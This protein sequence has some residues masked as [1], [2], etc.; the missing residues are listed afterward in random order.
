[1]SPRKALPVL[2]AAPLPSSS[3]TFVGH[4]DKPANQM[5]DNIVEKLLEMLVG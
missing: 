4:S 5:T 2:P 3:G 1:M